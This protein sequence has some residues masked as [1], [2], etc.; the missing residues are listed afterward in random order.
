MPSDQAKIK[1]VLPEIMPAS[2]SML[3]AIN[4]EEGCYN[5]A[6]A[7]VTLMSTLCPSKEILE[8]MKTILKV[9]V[10]LKSNILNFIVA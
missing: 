1:T 10:H 8:G 2:L 7:M 9:N 3:V 4:L 6:V 5:N